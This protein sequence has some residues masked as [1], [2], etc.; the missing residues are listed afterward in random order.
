VAGLDLS[1]PLLKKGLAQAKKESLSIKFIHGDMRDLSFEEI[2]TGCFLWQTS[3]GYF[4]DRT[5][6]EV[7]RGIH[8]ALHPGGQL[9][10]DVLNRDHIVDKM[11]HRLWWEGVDCIFLEEVELDHQTSVLHTK[12]SF[13]YEDGTPPL[14]H[15]SYIRLYACHELTRL[16]ESAGFVVDEV[17][18][19]LHHRG[20]F[21][22]PA[23]SRIIISARRR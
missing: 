21:L 6:F 14:E 13:I 17:S 11:P 10:I 9:L 20:H 16:L 15:N 12:R 1:M 7:L 2:F 22:G 4:D 3:F 18:G 23:S 8:R 5:N 19:E